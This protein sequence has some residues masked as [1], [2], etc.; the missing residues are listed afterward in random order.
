MDHI[1]DC[2]EYTKPRKVA[3]AAAQFTDHALTWWDRDLSDRRRCHEG[4]IPSWDVMKFIMR[5]RYVLPLYHR[6]LKKRFRKLQQDNRSIEEYYEEFEH[7]WNRLQLDESEETFMAQFPDVMQDRIVRKVERQHY[8]GFDELLHLAI[9]IE[10]QIKRK[11][12]SKPRPRQPTNPS[13]SPNVPVSP[14]TVPIN[15]QVEITFSIGLYRDTVMCD[16]VP[17]QASH[18]LL[19]RPWQFDNDASHNGRSNFYSFMHD[20]KRINLAPLV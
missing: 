12:A 7:L 18:V 1:F 11:N 8:I 13:W 20:Q 15:E 10:H 5:R 9:Q 19:G 3:Y 4:M 2:L 14:I 17:M 6:D 16:V